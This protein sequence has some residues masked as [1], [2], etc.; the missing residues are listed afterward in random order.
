MRIVGMIK[1]KY[2]DE[3]RRIFD[4]GGEAMT[5]LRFRKMTIPSFQGADFE[6]M[7]NQVWNEVRTY[8]AIN[9]KSIRI[10]D[11]IKATELRRLV[12]CE[13]SPEHATRLNAFEYLRLIG[14][15]LVFDKSKLEGSLRSG[16][17]DMIRSVA[18]ERANGE[19]VTVEDFLNRIVQNEKRLEAL[20]AAENPAL[21]QAQAA[22]DAIKRTAKDSMKANESV[23]T[24]ISNALAKGHLGTE[25]IGTI[26]ETVAKSLGK[27]LPQSYGFDPAACTREDI[28]VLVN[29]MF[30]AGRVSEMRYMRDKLSA[31]LAAAD[32]ALDASAA[33][34]TASTTTNAAKLSADQVKTECK[35]NGKSTKAIKAVA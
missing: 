35:R 4:I 12:A 6:A 16:W 19:R 32:M 1:A 3:S 25:Q 28:D 34:A 17:L 18:Y 10:A 15:A 2:N 20:T 9:P 24:A 8:V 31:R 11:W 30:A 27:S 13:I 22:V 21:A 33:K 14:K 7:C 26:F 5:V 29:V 23:T